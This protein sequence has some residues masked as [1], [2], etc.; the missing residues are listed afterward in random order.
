MTPT[1]AAPLVAQEFGAVVLLT[2]L[3]GAGKSTLASAMHANPPAAWRGRVDI[4]DGD[5]LR[6]KITTDLGFDEAS[7]E[8]QLL[9][10]TDLALASARDGRVAVCALIAPLARARAKARA[11]VGATPFLLIHVATSLAVCEE[12]DPKGLYRRARAG[13]ITEF[14]GVSSPY[15]EPEDAD[16][17]LDLGVLDITAACAQAWSVIADRVEAARREQ[18][19]S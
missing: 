1:H 9:R 3:S 13:E 6:A 15:Q 7:R 16:L 2:G 14:T 11:L 12:R 17:T 4:L 18:A 5:E 10:A 8:M 19:S